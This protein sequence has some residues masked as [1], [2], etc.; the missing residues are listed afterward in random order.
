MNTIFETWKPV[1]GYEGL[2]EVSDQG[3]VRG[4]DKIVSGKNGS[5]RLLRGRILKLNNHNKGYKHYPLLL[6]RK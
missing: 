1:K 4:L 5:N 3:Q 2:Y 6:P